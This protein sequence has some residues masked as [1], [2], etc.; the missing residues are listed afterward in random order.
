MHREVDGAHA[1]GREG[2]GVG[3]ARKRRSAASG[4]HASANRGVVA[5]HL[6]ETHAQRVV[7]EHAAGKGALLAAQQEFDCLGGPVR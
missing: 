6:V 7:E 2:R 1:L 3:R 4:E 5:A